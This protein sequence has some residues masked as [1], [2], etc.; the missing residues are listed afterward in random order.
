MRLPAA[1]EQKH[2]LSY[3]HSVGGGALPG[4]LFASSQK[5]PLSTASIILFAR[6]IA[7]IRKMCAHFFIKA[8]DNNL[9]AIKVETLAK[10]GAN[11]LEK[12]FCEAFMCACA[13]DKKFKA[14]SLSPCERIQYHKALWLS[15]IN[16]TG[17]HCARS[18]CAAAEIIIKNR[19]RAARVGVVR[20]EQ[21]IIMRA[22]G[23]E[24]SIYL[25]LGCGYFV[26][27][28]AH[29]REPLHWTRLE[30]L[31]AAS[32]AQTLETE[33][34]C[35]PARCGISGNPVCHQPSFEFIKL[36]FQTLANQL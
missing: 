7:K 20:S 16:R 34:L 5:L 22:L 23:C 26:M 6:Q 27:S 36:D 11:F 33:P 4:G 14:L 30:I 28:R 1:C 12:R 17:L 21:E 25:A 2:T 18:R 3:I 15:N 29:E 8:F 9:S 13:R 24:S 31:K 32:A 10:L 19:G 35:I